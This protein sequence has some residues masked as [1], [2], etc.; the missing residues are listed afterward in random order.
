MANNKIEQSLDSL[1][2][3]MV[4]ILASLKLLDKSFTD[5]FKHISKLGKDLDEEI[6]VDIKKLSKSVKVNLSSGFRDA[7]KNT[8]KEYKELRD[9]LSTIQNVLKLSGGLDNEKYAKDIEKLN[10]RKKEIEKDL[11][12]FEPKKEEK[13]D[14]AK[15]LGKETL[16]G[17][18]QLTGLKYTFDYIGKAFS[19]SGDIG[20]AAI[21][22]VKGLLV[23]IGL[24]VI[25]SVT[26][27]ISDISKQVKNI[28]K[29]VSEYSLSTSLVVNSQARTQALT[30]GLSDAQNYAFTQ[31]KSL[32]GI[33]SDEDLYYMNQNQ[34]EMFSTLMNTYSDLYGKMTENG[35]LE[36]FQEMQMDLAVIKT[37]F[38][39]E[40]VKFIANNKDVIVDFMKVGLTTL[41]GI[42]TIL[43]AINSF[44]SMRWAFGVEEGLSSD[45][46]SSITN[47]ASSSST[48]NINI[49][50]NAYGN[51]TSENANAIATSTAEALSNYFNS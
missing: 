22:G 3:V 35:S 23:D 38:S 43:S 7:F 2:D 25:K 51:S 9:E 31:V 15:P 28:I 17:V 19:A 14:I 12:N 8:K 18:E 34:R 46:I 32:M 29:E 26:D 16:R 33:S 5:S 37:E 24:K 1:N 10:R 40:I 47:N 39:A 49:S 50:A 21:G 11:E 44:I 6:D 13:L 36:E 30:Y 20:K 4:K 41:K 48:T 42:L 27:F 45:Y